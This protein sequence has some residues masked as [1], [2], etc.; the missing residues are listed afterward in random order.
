MIYEKHGRVVKGL[1]G[2]YE[3]LADDGEKFACRAKGNLKR[4]EE[5]VLI[6]DTVTI[7]VDDATPDGI[8]NRN[9]SS[10]YGDTSPPN[11]TTSPER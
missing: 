9:P 8:I 10:S 4:D 5:K 11:R 2:L 3:V 1:G 6:G 7:T